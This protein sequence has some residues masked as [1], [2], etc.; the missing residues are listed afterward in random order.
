MT[1]EKRNV[2]TVVTRKKYLGQWIDHT[3]L[4][5]RPC[6]RVQVYTVKGVAEI[7]LDPDRL[8]RLVLAAAKNRGK[9][10][11]AGPVKVRFTDVV[12]TLENE[13]IDPPEAKN[14]LDQVR[15][16]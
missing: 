14:R 10:S 2:N 13:H 5:R 12:E 4:T 3:S 16:G 6:F 8:D 11:T 7:T 1:M 9:K 15:K